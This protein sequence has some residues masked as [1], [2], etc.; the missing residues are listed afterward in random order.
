MV[1]LYTPNKTPKSATTMIADILELDYRGLGVAKI[2]GKAWFVENALPLERVQIRVL[3]EKR[4]YGRAV[5][6]KIL[7]PSPTR[8][9]PKCQYYGI[10]GGCRG[11]HISIESQREAKQNALFRRLAKLQSEAIEYMPMIVGEPWHYRRRLRLSL[12]FNPKTKTLN[13]GFRQKASTEIVNITQCE[14]IDPILNKTLQKLTALLRRFSQPK[15]LGHIELVAADNTVVLLLRH[16]QNLSENDR[17]LLMAFAELENISLFVQ[18]DHKI[19]HLYG[20]LPYYQVD[21]LTLWFD[22]R[23]FIQVN[24][25]LNRTMVKTALDWLDLQPQDHVLDLFCGMGNFTLPLSR[26]VKSAVGIEGVLEMVH[27][28]QSNAERNRCENVQFYQADLDCSFVDKPWA[29]L[30][31]NKILLDPPR[32]GAVFALNGLCALQAE[33][34]LYVSCNPATLVRDAEILINSGYCIQKTAM[35]DMFPHTEHLE[36]ITLFEKK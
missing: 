19:M 34:V 10:C 5:V 2:N 7:Q 16:L 6:Q 20:E 28:A 8:Q 18:D 22:V 33:K 27:K 32:T 30:P 3:E 17:S 25:E 11:Q 35:L 1:L 14:V 4:Q 12:G 26:R 24:A 36:S 21:G 23:D 15:L 31:F 13:I 9:I 29:T